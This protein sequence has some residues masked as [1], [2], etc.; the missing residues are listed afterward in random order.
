MASEHP[1]HQFK[2]TVARMGEY[3]NQSSRTMQVEV[4]VPNPEL[5]LR[6]GDY[7]QVTFQTDR[8][9][10]P[11]EIPASALAMKPQ[12]PEVA[13]VDSDGKVTFHKNSNRPAT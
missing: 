5:L 1:N 11:L 4:V 9:N 13:V 3:I 10:P 6:P 7:V 8:R 2:G 12:G